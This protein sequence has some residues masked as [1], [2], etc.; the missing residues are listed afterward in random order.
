M[1]VARIQTSWYRKNYQ[2]SQSQN[3]NWNNCWL[4]KSSKEKNILIST[5][6]ASC[7]ISVI[8]ITDHYLTVDL[9]PKDKDQTFLHCLT[10]LA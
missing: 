10:K 3:L 1:T 9:P 6:F 7:A 2:F 8:E 4:Y 5:L